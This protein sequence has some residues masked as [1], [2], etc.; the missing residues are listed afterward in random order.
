MAIQQRALQTRRRVLEAAAVVFD[1]QAFNS[2]S[3]SSILRRARVTKGA[4]YFHFGSKEELARSVMEEQKRCLVL[5]N[6][7]LHV[8]TVIDITQGVARL[9]PADPTLRASFRLTVEQG[10]MGQEDPS[11]YRWW[12]GIY[13][14]HLVQARHA[15]EL[16]AG[17]DPEDIAH[18]V[19][20]AF[21]GTHLLTR[22][23]HSH[24]DLVERVAAFWRTVLPGL[25][26]ERVLPRLAPYGSG[27]LQA[28]LKGA[29]REGTAATTGAPRSTAP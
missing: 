25:V 12:L 2:A 19:V 23:L 17:V 15:G 26:T 16:A 14:A 5:T 18:L 7:G 20:G 6:T 3:I 4:L 21:T 11:L 28:A 10:A 29:R 1:E 24:Q 13:C 22:V 9:I 8:Q 27:D